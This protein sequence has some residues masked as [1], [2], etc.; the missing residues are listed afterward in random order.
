MVVLKQ[1][2]GRLCYNPFLGKIHGILQMYSS[3]DPTNQSHLRVFPSVHCVCENM[4]IVLVLAELSC[5]R[6]LL[7]LPSI[8]SIFIKNVLK[9]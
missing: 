7:I 2:E 1:I 5:V 3:R 6:L 4:S 9:T 8:S